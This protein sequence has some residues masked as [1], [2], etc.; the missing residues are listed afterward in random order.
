MKK[1]QLAFPA[2]VS[3]YIFALIISLTF[4]EY[5]YRNARMLILLGLL[6]IACIWALNPKGLLV[7]KLVQ[8]NHLKFDEIR[9]EPRYYAKLKRYIDLAFAMTWGINV[10][11]SLF[12]TKF[13]ANNS[14]IGNNINY[15]NLIVFGF[16]IIVIFS[17]F[18]ILYS[19]IPHN[20]RNK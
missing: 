4:M 18:L 7:K 11:I 2:F 17:F 1:F 5:T 3:T 9:N 20:Y 14:T 8:Y 12:Q 15:D 19:F 6:G 13:I 10:G 16:D